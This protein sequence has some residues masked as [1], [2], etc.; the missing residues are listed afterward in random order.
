MSEPTNQI[1]DAPDTTPSPANLDTLLSTLH[2]H[3]GLERER[4]RQALVAIGQPAGPALI[5]LLTDPYHQVRWEAAKALVEIRDP[6]AAP[7]LV[8]RLEDEE[9]D[10]RWLAAEGLI[11]LG[12]AGLLPLL[13]ALVTRGDSVWLRQGAH[14]VLNS[15]FRK[16]LPAAVIAVLAALEDGAPGLVTP[17]AA[18]AALDALRDESGL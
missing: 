2:S 18:Q 8:A 13:A 7:T 9:F 10:M 5:D 17:Q 12:R 1:H 16:D 6:R 11:A 4:A 3:N 14:H 15:M